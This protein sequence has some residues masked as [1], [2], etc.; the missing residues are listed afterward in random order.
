MKMMTQNKQAERS[1]FIVT[2]Q[3]GEIPKVKEYNWDYV[4]QL[5]IL[6]TY[7]EGFLKLC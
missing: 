2:P 7:K 3:Q 6:K 5:S 1:I 4:Q